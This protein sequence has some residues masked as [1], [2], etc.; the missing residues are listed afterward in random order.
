MA[1]TPTATLPCTIRAPAPAPFNGSGNIR[2]WVVR[3][4]AY[5]SAHNCVDENTKLSVLTS[6][7]DGPALDWLT[8]KLDRE[9]LPADFGFVVRALVEHFAPESGASAAERDLGALIQ[10]GSL[11]EYCN[12]FDQLVVRIPDVTE[13]ERRR[14]FVRGLKPY[15]QRRIYVE[16][17]ATY[18]AARKI[19]FLHDGV[20]VP[21]P[22]VFQPT[23]STGPLQGCRDMAPMEVDNV[24]VRPR[25]LTPEERARL[26]RDGGCFSC[27]QKGHSARSCPRFP[28]RAPRVNAVELEMEGESEPT[29]SSDF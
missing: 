23:R 10:V 4:Q 1:E 26:I 16:A 14:S 3:L 20:N 2:H 7:L 8:Y 6:L 29:D 18:E 13:G 28:Y 25:K 21:R 22:S 12:R 19:A 9:Q 11:Q 27:R 24:V 15:L 17:A 5:Y